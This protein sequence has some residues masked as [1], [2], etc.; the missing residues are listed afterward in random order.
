MPFIVSDLD[1][2]GWVE[3]FSRVDPSLAPSRCHLLQ[4]QKGLRPNETLD[5]GVA[6]IDG[7]LD[8]AIPGW[9]SALEWRRRAIVE[10][11]TG[12][13]DL[14]GSTW[15]D[16]AAI[17]RGNGVYLVNDMVAAPGLLAEVSVNAAVE[18]AD[19]VCRPSGPTRLGSIARPHASDSV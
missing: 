18:A 13:L 7:L 10:H 4:G 9:S 5:E 11:E 2:P 14:P 12:A 1:E 19:S 15:R 6:R 8:V 16:R 17:D 3:T